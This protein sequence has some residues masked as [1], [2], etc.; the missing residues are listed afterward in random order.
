MITNSAFDVPARPLLTN[1]GLRSIRELSENETKLI[2]F[3]SLND[4]APGY[5]KKLLIRNSE[6]SCRALRNTGSDLKCH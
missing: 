1:L 6:H 4:L 2:E 5:L 3:K